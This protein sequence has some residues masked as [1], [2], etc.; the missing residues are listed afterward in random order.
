MKVAITGSDGFIAKNLIYNLILNKK[1]EILRVNRSTTKKKLDKILFNAEVI[2]H[3]AGANKE[4]KLQ[5]FNKDNIKLTSYICDY[6]L[7]NNLKK[8][9]IFSSSIQFRLNN[10]YGKSKKKM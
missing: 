4:E 1:F 2:F 7:K 3:F 9:I 6:L 10:K 8:K 5:N